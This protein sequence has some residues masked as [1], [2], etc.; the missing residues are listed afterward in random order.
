VLKF[1]TGLKFDIS[2]LSSPG[3]FSNGVTQPHF[4]EDG[5]T[6]SLNDKLANRVISGAITSAADFNIDTGK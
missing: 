5:T 2:D 6:P 1:V 3:F 4:N